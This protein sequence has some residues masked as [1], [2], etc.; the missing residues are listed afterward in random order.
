MKSATV[1]ASGSSDLA[2]KIAVGVTGAVGGLFGM[3]AIVAEL[4]ASTIIILRSIADIARSE[5]ADLN[6]IDGLTKQECLQV[7][8]LGTPPDEADAA[9]SAY[10]ASRAAMALLVRETGVA[11]ADISA[12]QVGAAAA[13]SVFSKVIEA[14]GS[15]L[16][17]HRDGEGGGPSRP[18]P[19]RSGRRDDQHDVHD[20]LSGRRKRALHPPATRGPVR[21]RKDSARIQPD[22]IVAEA[23]G[24]KRRGP[25]TGAN[26]QKKTFCGA[27]VR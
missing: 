5:G 27:A 22:P 7:F 10:Y 4:P 13:G 1:N 14:V 8:A 19:G 25:R 6:D 16:R 20:A 17:H 23:E 11:L 2:H 15:A 9:N 24:A 26:R 18:H 12:K 21:S 3:A